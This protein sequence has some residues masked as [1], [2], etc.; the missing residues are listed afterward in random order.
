MSIFITGSTGYIGSYVVEKLLR[1]HKNPLALLVRARNEDE[2]KKKLW[3]ALQLHMPF[4][5]FISFYESRIKVYLGDLTKH[6]LG[7]LGGIKEQLVDDMNSIIHV[8]ASL[9]R[10]SDKACFNN[11]LRGT[12]HVIKLAMASNKRRKLK[13]FSE[14]STAAV[15]GVRQDELVLENAMIDWDRSDYDPY[16]RTKKF[17]EYMAHELLE[18]IPK[19]I[20]R[21]SIVLGDSRFPQTTQFD[22]VRAFVTLSKLPVLPFNKNWRADIVPAN[23][24]AKAIVDIHQKDRTLFESYNLSAGSASLTFEQIVEVLSEHRGSKPPVFIPM[25]DPLASALVRQLANTPKWMGVSR[26]FSLMKVFWPYLNFNTVFDN[27]RVRQELDLVPEP[28]DQYA[29]ELSK[30]AQ[31]GQFNYAYKPWPDGA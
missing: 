19:T 23:F 12:L 22:M 14:V 9:N 7:L 28:F 13:R 21:P 3:K 15:A 2:A 25:L 1:E 20:F 5:E 31:D 30:F 27:S 4:D 17:C 11:N 26:L 8:A 24:V 16:A 29:Y 18:D 6:D 10:K